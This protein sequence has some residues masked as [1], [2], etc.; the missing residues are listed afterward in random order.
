[1]LPICAGKLDLTVKEVAPYLRAQAGARKGAWKVTVF[2]NDGG[3][4][5]SGYS[6]TLTEEEYSKLSR[7]M[8]HGLRN[9]TK[10]TS[11]HAG[12]EN[13]AQTLWPTGSLD[14]VAMRH[15]GVSLV[16]RYIT[17][18]VPDRCMWAYRLGTYLVAPSAL[19]VPPV[20]WGRGMRAIRMP[21]VVALLLFAACKL[22]A[23]G[24]RYL[25]RLERITDEPLA[26]GRRE[27]KEDDT[28]GGEP[29]KSKSGKDDR[30][31]S[32]DNGDS[33]PGGGDDK[34]PGPAVLETPAL[35]DDAE[36][37]AKASE[38]LRTMAVG[39]VVAVLG[40]N[41]D[42]EEP[43]NHL[44]VVGCLV[45]PCQR[46]PNVYAKTAANLL[47]AIRKRITEKARKAKLDDK[48]KVRIGRLVGKSMTP[49]K[50]C[51]VFSRDR[52]QEW[53]IAHFDLEA[54]KSGKWSTERFRGSLE[55][56]YAQEHPT[57]S[58]K[59][60][61][62]Y[63][64]M[65]EGKAPRMLIADGDEGQLMAL[66]V[67]KCF[68]ELLFTHFEKKS[69]KH[70][71]KREAIDRVLA[72]LRKAGAKA[73]EGDG[74]AW[75]TTCNVTIRG[76]VENPVLR[77]IMGEL[78]KFGVI[79]STWMEEHSIACEKKT[80]KLFFK[81]KFES[82]ATSIDAIRRSGHRGTSCLNWW[83]NYVMWVCS[84]FKEPERFLDTSVRN[85][86]DLSGRWRWWN[87]CFEGDD[88]LCTMCPPLNE[89]DDL[90]PIFLKFWESAGF[91]MK[92]VFCKDRATFVG[93]HLGCDEGE[94]NGVRCPE[95]PRALANS[96]VSVSPEG[97]KAAKEG[98]RSAVNVLAAASA[99]ARASDFAGILPSVSE[100]Y[101]EYAESVSQSDFT[102]REMSIRAFG[103]DGF[104]ASAVR[105]QI[106]ERNVE[107]SPLEEMTTMAR[108]GYRATNDE[109]ATF[110]EYVWSLDPA[111]LTD[112]DAFRASLPPA[113]RVEE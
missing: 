96:G 82:L 30:P 55:N 79:P 54:I 84:V 13:A 43:L 25:P 19:W 24:N 95:L 18:Q 14:H 23:I 91:N 85:G 86:V 97:I 90:A 111:V 60:D 53:A 112:Y 38:D 16:W 26:K 72:E 73:V 89:D 103:E 100:K 59:A 87:G 99:L 74:S 106:R 5:P 50:R 71:A 29:P 81:N 40:Q 63:E 109:V 22:R 8:Y 80:L 44:P 1:M 88:S 35:P 15:L 32:S 75:D 21:G 12:L 104:S 68:E 93:W 48:D 69:I 76:I 4:W 34:G 49:D 45:G 70:L 37:A 2:E 66:A 110:R 28:K 51:G 78:C 3:W 31:D 6:A 92:I 113:W 64:C 83:I 58:F 41:F 42:K 62:K 57:F 39:D 36:H 20:L 94:L 56:L 17:K 46:K 101:L 108:L 61:I 98:N 65:P 67:V 27:A 11:L 107:V 33:K 47:A 102:D 77:H 10:V 9:G 52:I 105:Q 7:T